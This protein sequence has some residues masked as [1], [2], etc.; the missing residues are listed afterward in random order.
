MKNGNEARDV[1]GDSRKRYRARGHGD[2]K[3]LDRVIN[4]SDFMIRYRVHWKKKTW[5][6]SSQFLFSKISYASTLLIP[7]VLYEQ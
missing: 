2:R 3:I 6:C 5:H 1:L 7:V 4:Q